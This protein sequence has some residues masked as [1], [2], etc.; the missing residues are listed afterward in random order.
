VEDP[1]LIRPPA[2][3]TG[4]L[5]R[6]RALMLLGSAGGVLKKSGEL[7]LDV[8]GVGIEVRPLVN[9]RLG[10]G[11]LWVFIIGESSPETEGVLVGKAVGGGLLLAWRGTTLLGGGE[12]SITRTQPGLSGATGFLA[13]ILGEFPEPRSNVPLRSRGTLV[14]NFCS[15]LRTLA[16][17]SLTICTPLDLE[18][19]ELVVDVRGPVGTRGAR[20]GSDPAFLFGEARR[21][22]ERL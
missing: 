7:G 22:F 13:V 3:K 16:R 17:I 15:R 21:E 9:E 4:T 11:I 14:C 19:F 20:P 6:L 10:P 2:G 8:V 5:V 1:K 18:A 12:S